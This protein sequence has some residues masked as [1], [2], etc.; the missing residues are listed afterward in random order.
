M[1]NS[2]D[3]SLSMPEEKIRDTLE[4]VTQWHSK[5]RASLHELR[6]LL[7]KLLYVAHVSSPARTFL[8]RMLATLRRCPQHG[9]VLLEENF[10]IH[11]ADQPPPKLK[12]M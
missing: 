2:L 11:P 4:L 8:N 9:S 1:F 3:M 7:G 5:Q 6:T 12:S 10:K